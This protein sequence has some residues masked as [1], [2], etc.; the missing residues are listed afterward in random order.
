MPLPVL[1]LSL[2]L[3]YWIHHRSLRSGHEGDE[4]KG[5]NIYSSP[6]WG[7]YFLPSFSPAFHPLQQT[8]ASIHDRWVVLRKRRNHGAWWVLKH[9]NSH[10]LP[11]TVACTSPIGV[12]WRRSDFLLIQ[13][14]HWLA[15]GRELIFGEAFI[16]RC[17][18]WQGSKCCVTNPSDANFLEEGE[19]A[20][21]VLYV[22]VKMNGKV[23]RLTAVYTQ[24]FF[25]MILIFLSAPWRGKCSRGSGP[26]LCVAFAEL[27]TCVFLTIL[28]GFS[29]ICWQFLT[30]QLS[31]VAFPLEWVGSDFSRAQAVSSPRWLVLGLRLI[32]SQGCGILPQHS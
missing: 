16:E 27:L 28:N 9:R 1:P 8:A 12:L 5:G 29:A 26:S 32:S 18:S 25:R 30:A 17:C 11:R 20:L 31:L 4:D 15:L 13:I 24:V 3:G 6:A 2:V 7:V 21:R 14:I 10:T 23:F 19:K 22:F